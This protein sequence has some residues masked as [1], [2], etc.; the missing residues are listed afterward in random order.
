MWLLMAGGVIGTLALFAVQLSQ[1]TLRWAVLAFNTWAVVRAFAYFPALNAAAIY[2]V[3][4][5]LLWHVYRC[6]RQDLPPTR[7]WPWSKHHSIEA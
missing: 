6:V 3:T 7:D 4:C 2:I 1:R 5:I